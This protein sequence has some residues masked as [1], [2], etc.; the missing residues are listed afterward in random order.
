MEVRQ[1][2]NNQFTIKTEKGLYFQSYDSLVAL[3]TNNNT[4]VLGE[5][6]RYSHTT[7][8]YLIQFLNVDSITTVDKKIASGEWIINNSFAIGNKKKYIKKQKKQI[9]PVDYS[10]VDLYDLFAELNAELSNLK[11]Y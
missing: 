2:A 4:V 5:D 3:I 8:K 7:M 6:Y 10:E 11:G 1:I 9:E